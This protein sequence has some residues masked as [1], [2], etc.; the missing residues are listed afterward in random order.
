MSKFHSLMNSQ[1]MFCFRRCFGGHGFMHF[2]SESN[3]NLLVVAEAS[4]VQGGV[5]WKPT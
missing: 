5:S 2:P 4:M 1:N 3:S